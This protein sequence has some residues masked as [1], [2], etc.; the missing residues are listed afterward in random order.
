MPVAATG[1]GGPLLDA[2]GR[3]LGVA[4]RSQP[5][6]RGRFIAVPATWADEPRTISRPAAPEAR[7]AAAE[8]K[9]APQFARPPKNIEDVPPERR[10]QIEKAFRPPP[11]VPSEL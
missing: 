1:A 4:S 3:V 10:E 6:D 5:D 7:P 2:F 9:P 11:N 8:P